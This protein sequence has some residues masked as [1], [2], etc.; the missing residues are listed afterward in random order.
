MAEPSEKSPEMTDF[1]QKNF[2]RTDYIKLNSCV[3]CSKPAI[4]FRNAI[5]KKEYTISGLCQDCQDSV[6]GKD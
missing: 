2:G 1:L 6:F 3:C 4:N 5:S